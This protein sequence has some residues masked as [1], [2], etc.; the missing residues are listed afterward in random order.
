MAIQPQVQQ[1]QQASSSGAWGDLYQRFSSVVCLPF[2]LAAAL[3][4]GFGLV[5]VRSAVFE[6]ELYSFSRQVIGVAVGAICLLLLW[7]VEYR[8]FSA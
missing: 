4:V 1:S 7:R 5:V 3:V 6:S 2:I 8:R